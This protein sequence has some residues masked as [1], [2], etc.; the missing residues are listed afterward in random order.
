MEE[1]SKP[2][3][4][5]RTKASIEEA[6]AKAAK[7]LILKKGFV[8]VT[9]LDIIKKAKIEPIPSITDRRIRRSFTIILYVSLII[10]LTTR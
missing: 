1:E 8:G 7:D 6:I 4:A 2:R 10:G 3:R 9:V 5:R